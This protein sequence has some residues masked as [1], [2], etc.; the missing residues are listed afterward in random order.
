MI[1][2]NPF[3]TPVSVP[4]PSEVGFKGKN[5]Y[6]TL[7]VNR[8]NDPIDPDGCGIAIL[9]VE[10]DRADSAPG[11]ASAPDAIRSEL[12]KLYSTD[13]PVRVID[14]GNIKQ[15]ATLQDTRF[16]V[17][18]VCSE[19][20]RK[21]MTIVVLGGSQDLTLPL[22]K[23]YENME[24]TVNL[25]TVDAR[26]DFGGN[27]DLNSGNYLNGIVLHSP[28]YLFGYCN[29]A[30]QRYLNPPEL[31]R[32]LK[33][34]HFDNIRLG[35]L[36]DNI[37]KSEPIARN[38]D[39]M[40]FDMTAIKTSEAPGTHSTEPN[41]LRSEQ[42]CT[43]AYHAGFS[44]KLTSFG[45]FGVV[46][47]KD[48]NGVTAALAAQMVWCFLDGFSKRKGD[49]PMGTTEDYLKYVVHIEAQD[50]E[51]VFYKS[52]HSDRWWMEVPYPAGM[53]NKYYRHYLVPCTYEDY[54]SASNDD[55][56]DLWWM[57][58]QKLT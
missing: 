50:H 12:Y 41:G 20:L 11:S 15:G 43:I 55:I 39:L 24:Q 33:D 8:T 38:A 29:L 37:L 1:D 40:S 57:T 21:K 19:L 22:F 31:F 58:Y 47:G 14:L 51:I 2:P 32:M 16:A 49:Y 17:E 7:V 42:A 13:F 5:L 34:L 46:P 25:V 4:A 3:L 52:P 26:L 6:S 48:S 56:P 27:E 54:L 28:N 44:D 30:N 36:N 10:E 45:L 18:Q 9:G 35:D 23:A 53:Q